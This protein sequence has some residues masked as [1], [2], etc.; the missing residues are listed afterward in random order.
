MN[1][2]LINLQ[3]GSKVC[4]VI[5]DSDSHQL[6]NA[7]FMDSRIKDSLLYGV[8]MG[9]PIF[10]EKV[11]I[12]SKNGELGFFVINQFDLLREED[13]NK[14]IS[15]IKDREFMGYT[16]PDNIII[17]LTV[18]NEEKLQNISSEV[19]HFCVVAM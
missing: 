5:K 13:Q 19:Y 4:V 1:K 18:E 6:E 10:K 14:Y 7:I 2:E 16:I 15:L 17:I 12:I 9:K 11:E 3:R 8:K